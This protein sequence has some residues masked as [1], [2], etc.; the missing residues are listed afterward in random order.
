MTK[1]KQEPVA[2]KG[3]PSESDRRVLKRAQAPV[4]DEAPKVGGMD[5]DAKIEPVDL[6]LHGDGITHRQDELPSERNARRE[7]DPQ[8]ERQVGFQRPEK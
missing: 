1:R 8:A 4:S 2:G 7:H 3:T 5:E 6:S